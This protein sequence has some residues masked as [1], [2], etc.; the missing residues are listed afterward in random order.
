MLSKLANNS[1]ESGI[2]IYN[3][4]SKAASTTVASY[5]FKFA[6][7][8]NFV[9]KHMPFCN[10]YMAKTQLTEL[11]FLKDHYNYSKKPFSSDQHIMFVNAVEDYGL[12][13]YER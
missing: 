3:K 2:L 9:H 11:I 13:N 10:H 5:M 12:E 4:V 1:N 6:K 8:N 7:R